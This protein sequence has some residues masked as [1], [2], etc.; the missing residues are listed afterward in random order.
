M[1]YTIIHIMSD[2]TKRENIDGLVVKL[3]EAT[4]PAYE[5]ICDGRK[6]RADDRT[7]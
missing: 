4:Q 1:K 6:E 7:F 2:G 5:I 3:N